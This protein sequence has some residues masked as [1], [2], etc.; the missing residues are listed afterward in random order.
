MLAYAYILAEVRLMLTRTP[1]FLIQ[2][3]R[4]AAG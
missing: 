3:A 2:A 1:H 4:Q